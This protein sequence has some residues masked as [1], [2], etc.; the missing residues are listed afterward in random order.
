MTGTVREASRRSELNGGGAPR[1]DTVG[2]NLAAMPTYQYVCR[3]CEHRFEAVQSIHDPNLTE[4]PE[5][6][7]SIR[8]V[9]SPVGVTFK[10]SGFYR[11]DSRDTKKKSKAAGS[12]DSGAAGGGGEGG[13]TGTD[14]RSDTSGAKK[15]GEGGSS[16]ATGGSS[17]AAGAASGSAK[18][19]GSAAG[20]GSSGKSGSS[21]SKGA[22]G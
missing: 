22:S 5:C 13:S 11:T 7:G 9:L 18:G 20:S 12:A 4:C 3:D 15:A 1:A 2:A 19:G 16:D 21:G 6:G 14:K 8:R 17:G 10:G